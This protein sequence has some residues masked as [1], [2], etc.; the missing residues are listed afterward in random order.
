MKLWTRIGG[1]G[2][3]NKLFEFFDH[4]LICGHI[5]EVVSTIL[6]LPKLFL[7]FPNLHTYIA[8]PKKTQEVAAS[9]HV[10]ITVSSVRQMCQ[11]SSQAGSYLR[12]GEA[13][14]GLNV[15]LDCVSDI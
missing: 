13:A 5:E 10:F 2:E 1:R 15:I 11:D 12:V 3:T 9:N 8:T 4:Y 7:I 14:S 6:E